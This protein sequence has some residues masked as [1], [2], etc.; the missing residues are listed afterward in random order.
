[1]TMLE[2]IFDE[3]NL[4]LT[5]RTKFRLIFEEFLQQ[6][7]KQI[8]SDNTAHNSEITICTD[9]YEIGFIKTLLE[10]LNK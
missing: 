6:K 3:H 4:F 2:Q 10:D 5:D 7:Q 1:M 8:D 9:W